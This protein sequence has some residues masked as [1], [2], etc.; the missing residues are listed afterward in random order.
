MA[1]ATVKTAKTATE[2]KTGKAAATD[3]WNDLVTVKLFKDTGNY[4]DDV[5]VSVNGHNYLLQ[6]G[7]PLKIPRCVAEVLQH[8]E[9]QDRLASLTVEKLETDYRGKN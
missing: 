4:K 1:D 8:S 9:E 7:V 5:F 6:R 2:T 3:P